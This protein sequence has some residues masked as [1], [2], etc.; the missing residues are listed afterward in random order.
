MPWFVYI[1]FCDS[2]KYYIGMTNNIERRLNQHHAGYSFYTKQYS[3]IE[4]KYFEKLNN[5]REAE[6][7]EKQIKGWSVAKKK[8]LIENN[9]IALIELSKGSGLVEGQSS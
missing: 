4:L 9:K 6:N 8:A 2:K 3:K 7:R 5:F 1:L